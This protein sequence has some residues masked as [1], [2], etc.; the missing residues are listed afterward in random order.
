[1]SPQL[2]HNHPHGDDTNAVARRELEVRLGGKI[3]HEV[4]QAIL[5]GRLRNSEK[6]LQRL[7][8]AHRRGSVQ[9]TPR[10][11]A[12]AF[13]AHQLRVQREAR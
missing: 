8:L 4:A 1:M 11:A 12:S 10:I 6:L 5:D 2:Y 7:R 9:D 3:R 13:H